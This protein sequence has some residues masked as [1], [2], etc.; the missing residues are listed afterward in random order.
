MISIVKQSYQV[1]PNETLIYQLMDELEKNGAMTIREI[2]V[3]RSFHL[4]NVIRVAGWLA[5]MNFV[6]LRN[7]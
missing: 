2:S 7:G 5:K 1:V 6:T 4:R 3:S